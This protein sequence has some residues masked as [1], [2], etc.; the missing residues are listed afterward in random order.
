MV[1]L[2]LNELVLKTKYCTYCIFSCERES[3]NFLLQHNDFDLDGLC[4]MK[5]IL[6]FPKDMEYRYRN[7][8]GNLS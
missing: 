5:G 3:F 1:G 6:Q 2:F 8:I 7:Y 4:Y